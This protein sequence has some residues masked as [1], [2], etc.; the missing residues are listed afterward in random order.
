M[1][2]LIGCCFDENESKKKKYRLIDNLVAYNGFDVKFIKV[3]V[4]KNYTCCI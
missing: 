2:I 3:C 1:P 4:I